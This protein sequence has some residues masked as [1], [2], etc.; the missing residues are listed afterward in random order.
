MDR[1]LP[2]V[3]AILVL[4][5]GAV[6]ARAAESPALERGAAITDPL[7]LR[8]LDRGRFAVARIM[9]PERS[10]DVPLTSGLL[11]ALPSMAM[12]RTALDAEF[13]RYV[14][15]HKA[16]LPNETIGVGTGHD[17]QLF[18][19]A[20]LDSGDTRFVLAGIVNRMDR[21]FLSPESCGEV[22]LIYRLTRPAQAG[23][24]GAPRR[25]P[26]TLNIV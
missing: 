10:V 13:D 24:D 14:V 8:E 3:L 18:D 19:R 12:V 11:F 15:R 9:V 5:C 2:F 23:E 7:A 26:M 21:A 16:A 1:A 4:L 20:L 17:F 22:R 25:L 6:S